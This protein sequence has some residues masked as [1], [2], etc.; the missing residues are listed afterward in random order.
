MQ[1]F[2]FH[3]LGEEA[4][5]DLAPKGYLEGLRRTLLELSRGEIPKL[6][7]KDQLLQNINSVVEAIT[8]VRAVVHEEV[9][10]ML[11]AG[12]TKPSFSP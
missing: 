10:K 9:R 12:V 8:K 7:I 6:L 5:L 2:H 11:D 1:L 3:S 4:K